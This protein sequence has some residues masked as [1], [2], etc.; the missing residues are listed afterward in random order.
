MA[1]EDYRRALDT[2]LREYEQATAERARLDE[3]IAQ[4][5]QSIATLTKLC[6]YA[7]TV[8]FGLT[9]A[10][11]LALRTAK[12]P[13][14]AVDVRDH[15]RSIGFELER[16]ANPLAAIH[17]VLKRLAASGEAETAA[18]NQHARVAYQFLTPRAPS[19][20]ARPA[21]SGWVWLERSRREP[22]L[23]R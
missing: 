22:G 23:T 19:I 16:Y 7:P 9:D 2:A 5:H 12:R 17:T 18:R 11:R 14:S 13:L 20:D 21:R 15:L 8:P 1:S 4:L 10:C 6:G 3:R